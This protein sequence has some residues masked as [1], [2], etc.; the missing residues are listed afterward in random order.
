M[1]QF[2]SPLSVGTAKPDW[3]QDPFPSHLF[4]IMDCPEDVSVVQFQNLARKAFEQCDKQGHVP[5]VV[6]GA[7]FYIKSLFFPLQDFD[8]VESL[9]KHKRHF[10]QDLSTP[11]L[12]DKL[13]LIDPAR[14]LQLHPND[15]YRIA[16]ALDIWKKTGKKPSECA[17]RYAPRFDALVVVLLPEK[18][19]LEQR[20]RLRVVQMIKDQGWIQEAKSLIGTQ[21]EDFVV[22]KELIG[23]KELFE[24]I[25]RGELASELE[26]VI[27]AI[28]TSTLQYAKRQKTFLKGFIRLLTQHKDETQFACDI[29]SITSS[30]SANAQKIVHLF[31]KTNV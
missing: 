14:A 12:W 6:G 16:R 15:R 10:S 13:E 31:K 22:K 2:Y 27:C 29:V 11:Q 19:I 21:W 18:E 5:I 26:A 7:F 9:P 1:G 4:D 25:K 23:Y 30:D 24:W 8:H 3:K 28:Q 20:I 17:P